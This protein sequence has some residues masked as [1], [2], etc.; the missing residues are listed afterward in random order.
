MSAT[1]GAQKQG[2]YAPQELF[3]YKVIY[4]GGTYIRISPAVDSER[5]GDI[6]EY[7]VIFEASK[8][9]VL[10]GI[11]YVK[12]SDGRGWVFGNKGDTGVLELIDV[13]RTPATLSHPVLTPMRIR[14]HDDAPSSSSASLSSSSAA[15]NGVTPRSMTK[16]RAGPDDAAGDRGRDD[17]G[18]G[19]T[20]EGGSWGRK[21]PAPD[22]FLV[23]QAMVQKATQERDKLFQGVRAENRF[24]KGVRVQC[25]ACGTFD[26]LV[27]LSC[28][29]DKADLTSTQSVAQRQDDPIWHCIRLIASIARQCAPDVADLTGLESALW[30]LV[31]LGSRA[32][33]A[34]ELAVAAA[35]ER[36]EAV[37]SER[38][39]ELLLVVLEAGARAK[40]HSVDLSKMVDI[41]P[42]DIRNFLQRWIIIKVRALNKK[43]SSSRPLHFALSGLLKS[44]LHPTPPIFSVIL[45]SQPLLQSYETE[46]IMEGGEDGYEEEV[47]M[48]HEVMRTPTAGPAGPRWLPAWFC[49]PAGE[50][51]GGP[52][53]PRHR[54]S[55]SPS[56]ARQIVVHEDGSSAT[57]DDGGE[58]GEYE[59][60]EYEDEEPLGFWSGLRK[61]VKRIVAD[62]D[63]QLA[64]II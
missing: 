28:E 15:A 49:N 33:H 19:K 24:W 21:A 18:E 10:D 16:L 54:P 63:M 4:P 46:F 42:D 47:Y 44:N 37:S 51:G 45:P 61:H 12:L 9:L 23:Q 2:V 35:N 41:L 14:G 13:T 30:V 55:R 39:S 11:N 7:G 62:P 25:L 5:T 38:Q 17:A 59:G 48:E 29:L 26:E 60:D 34:M 52:N 3:R 53:Q 64:G 36:F 56:K 31:H 40:P 57:E 20:P 8:S 6:I 50:C 27:V 32:S 22:I 58:F 1:Q 43:Y